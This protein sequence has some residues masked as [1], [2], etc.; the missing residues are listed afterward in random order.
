MPL[1]LSLQRHVVVR[2]LEMDPI[3]PKDLISADFYTLPPSYSQPMTYE[4]FLTSAVQFQ[5]HGTGPL[6]E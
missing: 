6:F 5:D 2:R 3:S 4:N 1:I